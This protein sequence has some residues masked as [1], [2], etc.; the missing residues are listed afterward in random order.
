MLR[1]VI[2]A[3]LV[4]LVVQ[5]V[6]S[7]IMLLRFFRRGG[8]GKT[9]ALDLLEM[10]LFGMLARN[11]LDLLLEAQLKPTRFDKLLHLIGNVLKWLIIGSAVLCIL[12]LLVGG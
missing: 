12:L 6:V 1:G 7:V 11:Y 2:I 9:A 10:V 5:S 4:S 8:K 3:I